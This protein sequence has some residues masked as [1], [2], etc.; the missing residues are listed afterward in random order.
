MKKII[1]IISTVLVLTIGSV[2]LYYFL[3]LH[4]KTEME[5]ERESMIKGEGIDVIATLVKKGILTQTIKTT[6]KIESLDKVE[7]KSRISAVVENIKISDGVKVK[8]GKK[9]IIFNKSQLNNQMLKSKSDFMKSVTELILELETNNFPEELKKWRNYLQKIIDRKNVPPYPKPETEKMAIILS[10]LNV[11][12]A[13]NLLKDDELKLSYA[14]MTAPFD[15][16]I[17]DVNINKGDYILAGSKLCK[18]TNLSKMRLYINI[19]EE[20][21][22]DIEIGSYVFI[23]NSKK[24]TIKINALLP[25]IDEKSRTGTAIAIYDNQDLIYKDGQNIQVEVVKNK[26]QD[27]VIIPRDALLNRNNRDLVFIIING[28]AQWRYVDIGKSNSEFIEIKKGVAV[29]DTVVIGG[30][31]SLGHNVKVKISELIE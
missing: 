10:R 9:L 11:Q 1:L 25:S 30:H 15:G 7:L 24:D 4:E 26:Y 2:S 27:R 20:D 5:T 6:A 18:L 17:S 28:I 3:I 23:N 16:I 21:I 13:Y 31:Y 19:L 12:S 8:Q 14:E 29:G 22:S